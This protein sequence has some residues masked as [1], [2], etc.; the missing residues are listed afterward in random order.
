MRIGVI[1]I[2]TNAIQDWTHLSDLEVVHC[3]CI[4]DVN[5][6]TTHRYNEQN[7][8]PMLRTIREGLEHATK[9]DVLVAHN[10]IDFDFPALLKLYD[11]EHPNVMDTKVMARCIYPDIKNVDF[12]RDGFEPKLIGS[13]SLKSW[14]IRIGE[15]KG[16]FGQDTDWSEWSKEMEDYC[17][18]DVIVT[19]KL[20][21]Y[22]MKKN[23][24]NPMLILE[25]KFATS[26]REQEVNGFPFD[27]QKA[28]ELTKV[29]N[30]RR[31]ELLD[32]LQEVFPP[33]IE[34]M[35]SRIWVTPH[36]MEFPTKKQAAAEGYKEA[37]QGRFKTKEI[38]FNPNSRDQIAE[39]LMESGWKPQAYEGKR[40]AINESVL[41]SIGTEQAD[42][43]LE[44]LTISKRLGQ[45]IDG[46]NAWLKMLKNNCIH[47]KV[48]TNGTVSGRCSHMFPNIA[49]VPATSA[50]Y[51]AECRELF[52]PPKGKVLVGCDA[53][54]LELRCLAHYLY[55]WDKGAYGKRIVED[56]I[57]TVN[58]QAAGL[59]TRNQAKTFIYGW[60]YGAGDAKIGQIVGGSSRDGKRLKDNFT[61]QLPAVRHLLSAV[62]QKVESV[63]ILKGLDGRDLPARSG[64]SALNLLLQSAG[65]V[66]M[67]QALIEFEAIASKFYMLHAN[68]HDEVQFSCNEA[69]SVTLGKE[70]VQAIKNAGTNLNFHCPLDGEYHIGQSW[71]E[72][73]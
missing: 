9:F 66:I 1:D 16:D 43:L 50:P 5:N 4:Y 12:Q 14:G 25:H 61:S 64:H 65:A 57:H 17:V 69:D 45:L 34:T 19:G 36:G 48:N 46:K 31:V 55:P 29:L 44:F 38:P 18:Q 3:I 32:E 39:R 62:K 37:V 58:Q 72:T 20:Y 33:K 47:G 42:K 11:F 60:L 63:G 68:V 6:K 49:Q 52:I 30:M 51:G 70:F 13:H 56:D 71:K 22:L 24:S 67:K 7:K 35:K 27:T 2:E 26:M 28:E 8:Y 59:E 21:E 41:R 10:G 40:P 53:S 54:G 15:Y 23:P 73:H